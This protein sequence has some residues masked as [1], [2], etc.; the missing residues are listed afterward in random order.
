MDFSDRLPLLL[1]IDYAFSVDLHKELIYVYS[2]L[3]DTFSLPR[4]TG[5]GWVWSKIDNKYRMVQNWT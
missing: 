1:I 5:H 4:I 2:Y 3:L